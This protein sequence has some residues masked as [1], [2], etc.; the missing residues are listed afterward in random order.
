MKWDYEICYVYARLEQEGEEQRAL[1]HISI[2][3]QG[4]YGLAEGLKLLGDRG[5]ELVGIHA[6]TIRD[7]GS[8]HGWHYHPEHIYIFKRPLEPNTT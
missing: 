6:H 7:L 4:E 1:W 8:L 5:W 3:D 2:R